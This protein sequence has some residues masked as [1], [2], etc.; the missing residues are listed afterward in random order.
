MS[1]QQGKV[2]FYDNAK[3]FGFIKPYDGNKDIF[4]HSTQLNKVGCI[5]QDGQAVS[6]DTQQGKRGVEA[7]DIEFV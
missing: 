3:G 7:I 1:R 2:K 4:V 5:L 6:F